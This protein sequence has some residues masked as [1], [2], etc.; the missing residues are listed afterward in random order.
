MMNS[1]TNYLEKIRQ[2]IKQKNIQA[3][4][5]ATADPHLNEY[6]PNYW[7]CRQW[8]TGFIGSAGTAVITQNHAG[9]WTD[10]RYFVQAE[11]Q[12]TKPFVLHKQNSQAQSH[13]INWIQNNM[14]KGDCVGYNGLLFD[15]QTIENFTNILSSKNIAMKDVGDIFENIWTNRPNI[16]YN[17]IFEHDTKY[18]GKTRNE[19][20][21]LLKE[22]IKKLEAN[23][24]LITKLDDIAWL[25]NIRG[26]DIKY[27]PVAMAYLLI[28]TEQNTIF[29]DDK[30]LTDE[31]KKQ[32]ETENIFVKPYMQIEN[33]LNK[34]TKNTTLLLDKS[35]TNFRVY[36][37]IH[38]S[39]KV[40]NIS[41]IVAELKAIKNN[42]EINNYK[43]TQ[44]KDS[45]ALCTFLKWLNDN[46][47]KERITELSAAQKLQTLRAEQTNFKD[48]SFES[49]S[50]FGANSAL[51]HYAP[52]KNSD[53][54][55]NRSN[56]Y[57]IDSGAQYLD[58]T[59]DITRTIAMGKPTKQQITDFTLVL[60][61]HIGLATVI[62]PE[63]TKGYQLDILARQYLWEQ[64][65]DYGHG[66]GHGVGFF[67]NVHE[68]PQGIAPDLRETSKQPI[69]AGMIITN[70]PGFYL[71]G[72]YGIRIE[73]TLLCVHHKN[74]DFGKFLAFETISYCPIDLNLIDKNMLS[75]KEIKWINDYHKKTYKLLS[76]NA[77]KLLKNWLKEK[78][79]EI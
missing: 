32:W 26:N 73:N 41:N 76:A 52:N 79:K 59:T 31:I 44:I 13:Y 50:A 16:T 23:S 55:I 66:T 22:K 38:S 28:G 18:A 10:S 35:T 17:K 30:K 78:T 24:L 45:I 54:V 62:F 21:K 5:V 29:I 43:Q 69:Y 34:K 8:I 65:K 61:G 39:C 48:I 57:L 42:V 77:N 58:G 37:A 63:G 2:E 3:L 27:N 1:K 47:D 74:S 49:I 60:K 19:K 11:K 75:E 68:G 72:Q 53:T 71:N 25:L 6:I 51:P 9:L 7:K 64:G 15:T 4:I 46:C 20:I 12:L 67:L 14:Q 56:L 33:I 70:E 36:N 40:L